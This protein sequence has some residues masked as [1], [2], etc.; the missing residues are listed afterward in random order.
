M[1]AARRRPRAVAAA[2]CVEHGRELSGTDDRDACALRCLRRPRLALPSGVL[3]AA[4]TALGV[5]GLPRGSRIALEKP[6]GDDLGS[7]MALNALLMPLT[8]VAGERAVF[9]FDH[10][11]GMATVQ[12]LVGVRLANRVLEPMWN[13]LHIEQVDIVWDETLALEGRAN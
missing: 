6:F 2:R 9:R 12:N 1:T 8:G 13:G 3:S 11:L 10:A 7:A 4:V 5:A